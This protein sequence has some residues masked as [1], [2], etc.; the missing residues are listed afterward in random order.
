MKMKNEIEKYEK[1]EIDYKSILVKNN[2]ND[3]R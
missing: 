3:W 2:I 1:H